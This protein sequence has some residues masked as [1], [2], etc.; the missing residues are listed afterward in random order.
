MATYDDGTLDRCPPVLRPG[1]KEHVLV[2]QDESI[3]H[4]NESRR[5][6]WLAQDQQQ[7]RSKGNGRA[8]HVSDFITETIGRLR[9]SNEQIADQLNLPE[10]QRLPAFEARKVTYPGKGFDAWWD[11][12]QL[13]EQIKTT[14]KVFDY[15]HPGCTAIFTFDRSSAHE[16]FAENALNVNNMNINPGGKQRKMH[17]TIIPHCN[18][19]PAPGEED[20]RGHA[21]Q[22]N[23]PDDHPDPSLRGKAKGMRI[24]LQERKSVWA[25]LEAHCRQHGGTK[26]V[27][28]CSSCTKSQTRKDAE[29]RVAFV[30]A[31]GEDGTAST[32][33]IALANS[34]TPSIP[35]VS[36]EWCCMYRV[37]ALQE[38]FRLEK[39]LIQLLIEEAGHVCLF[40]PRFHCE[41]NP[42]EMLWGYGKFRAHIS[43]SRVL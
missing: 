25:K 15:T 23:F 13:I 43:F 10:D 32:E 42:I 18:P 35:D 14:I 21:Q 39:P 22:M 17:D 6:A 4:T 28:K 30:E 2:M 20:T 37:L 9:L 33:D 7:I 29:R 11:L 8:I 36:D 26:V 41:L 5:R 38:D 24:V 40:L 12:P 1:E 3:F 34:D 16:G 19:D 27:G 31:T